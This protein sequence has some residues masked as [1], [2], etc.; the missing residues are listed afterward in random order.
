MTS[1]TVGTAAPE[2]PI[3]SR[4]RSTD[5]MSNRQY[6]RNRQPRWWARIG[7]GDAAEW[8]EIGTIRGDQ[9]LDVVVP[10]P[11]GTSVHIGCGPRDNGIRETVETQAV[12]P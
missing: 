9:A 7:S 2:Q 11:P 3:S 5:R 10:L 12:Q 6:H 4:L 8:V 1:E